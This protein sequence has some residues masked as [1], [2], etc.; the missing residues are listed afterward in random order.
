MIK[1]AAGRRNPAL[2]YLEEGWD[3][4]QGGDGSVIIAVLDTGVAYEDYSVPDYEQDEVIGDTYYQAPELSDVN[5]VS[6]YDFIHDVRC[7]TTSTATAP[8]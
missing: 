1:S 6:P 8:T 3:I 4:N 2:L 5:F 7:P